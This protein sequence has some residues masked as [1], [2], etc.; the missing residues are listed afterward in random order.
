MEGGTM[1]EFEAE[2]QRML[3]L[4]LA[5][6]NYLSHLYAFEQGAEESEMSMLYWRDKMETLTSGEMFE[7]EETF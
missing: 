4:D 6:R 1:S 7:T 5:V 2:M 3:D